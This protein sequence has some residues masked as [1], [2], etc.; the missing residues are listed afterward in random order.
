MFGIADRS[1]AERP[2]RLRRFD[3]PATA[4]A[5]VL[6]RGFFF[7]FFL[8]RFV[9]VDAATDGLLSVAKCTRKIGEGHGAKDVVAA[10]FPA[11]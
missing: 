1:P 3:N 9:N 5:T 4:T 7:R 10:R 8:I 2:R 6:V 11:S